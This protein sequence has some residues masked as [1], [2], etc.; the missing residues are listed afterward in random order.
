MWRDGTK[1]LFECKV[2]ETGAAC[3]TGG[4]VELRE[5]AGLG[6]SPSP[7]SALKCDK[8]FQ[9]LGERL[10]AKPGNSLQP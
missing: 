9:Q 4:W 5:D 1:I 10:K 7:P 8:I 6:S 3:L 2:K